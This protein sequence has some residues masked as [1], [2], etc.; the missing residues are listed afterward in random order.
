M[1]SGNPAVCTPVIVYVN[2]ES[3]AFVYPEDVASCSKFVLPAK[4]HFLL[5][6]QSVKPSLSDDHHRTVCNKTLAK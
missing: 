5:R 4:A 3:L 2:A 6:I 1:L